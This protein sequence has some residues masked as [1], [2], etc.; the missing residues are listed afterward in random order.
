MKDTSSGDDDAMDIS[1]DR[2]MDAEWDAA[3]DALDAQRARRE[4]PSLFEVDAERRAFLVEHPWS[5][6]KARVEA[7]LERTDTRRRLNW[8][9]WFSGLA[10]ACSLAVVFLVVASQSTVPSLL[11]GAVGDDLAG[12]EDNIRSKGGEGPAN[13]VVAGEI[14]ATLRVIV[15]GR[16]ITPGESLAAETELTFQVDSG[17]YD[18]V[19]VFSLE[20]SGAITPYYPESESG[21]SL[22]IGRGRGLWL[23]DSV[24][25]DDSPHS[26]LDG[27]ED[28]RRSRRRRAVPAEARR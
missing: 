15:D 16:A 2:N 14:E 17:D 23:P 24:V 21:Q 27:G 12:L 11:G 28:R 6:F 13:G 1:M 26:E 5:T 20:A 22:A 7:R 3:I 4:E 25:L 8:T 10:S 19:L 18:H 9:L